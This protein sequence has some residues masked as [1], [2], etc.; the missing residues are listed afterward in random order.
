MTY[1]IKISRSGYDVKTCADRELA[2]SSSW[3]SLKIQSSGSATIADTGAQ[4][5]ATHGLGY[6]PAFIIMVDSQLRNTGTE[7]IFPGLE[8]YVISTTTE[9]KWTAGTGT[10][11]SPVNVYYHIF[12]DDLENGYASPSYNAGDTTIGNTGTYG[13]KAVTEGHNVN[14][15]DYRDYSA[16]SSLRSSMVH[17]IETGT[18][19]GNGTKTVTHNLGYEPVFLLYGKLS[20][21]TGFQLFGS[22]DDCTIAVSTTTIAFT[23]TLLS[24]WTYSILILKDNILVK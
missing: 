7:V 12:V 20:G 16:I 15:T 24:N 21:S 14:D 23:T 11:G 9:L 19:A 8:Q 3:P 13:I 2:F 10:W 22:A 1:G 6:C 5:L 17:M 4:V 18:A